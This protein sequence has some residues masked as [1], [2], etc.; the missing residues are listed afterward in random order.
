MSQFNVV[1]G[2]IFIALFSVFA[3][4]AEGEASGGLP[5]PQQP[6]HSPRIAPQPPV[7]YAPAPEPAP[8]W[9][10]CDGVD[11]VYINNY[12]ARIYPFLDDTPWLQPYRF[13]SIVTITNMGY[14]TVEA[15]AMGIDFQHNEILVDAEGI[16]LEDGRLMPVDV[17][18]GTVLTQ[19]P[20]GVLK[21]AIETAGDMNQVQKTFK[22]KGTEFGKKLD[23]MPRSINI[24]LKG[25]NC[26]ESLLYGNNTMHTCCSE[27]NRNVT[28]N[29]EEFFL[30]P[31][32][33][34]FTIMYDVIQAYPGSYLA[35]VTL[36][37]DSPIARLDFWNI[38]FTWQEN[39]FITKMMGA[40]TREADREVCMN[41]IAGKTYSD[42]DMNN[43]FC[44]SV[45]PEIV[46]L[47]IDRTNDTQIG[48]IEYCCRNGTLWPAL[49]DEKKS[50]SAFL[51]NVYKVPPMSSQLNHIIPP[52]NWRIGDGR[53][54]CGIPRRIKPTAYLDP[55]LLYET[56]AF[57][58]WQVT[59]N[60]TE[61]KPPPKCCVSFSKYTNDSIVP[62]RTCACGCP[63]SPQPACN[64]SASA[65]LL[66][67]SAITMHPENRTRQI[68]AWA[69]I[70]HNKN[71]PNPLPCQ[72]Y[73]GVAINWHIV[74]NFT[75][76]WSSRMTLF[77]WSDVTFPDWF[78]VLQMPGAYQGF[79]QAYSFNATK[80]P[81]MNGTAPDNTSVMVTGLQ[82]L[83][84]LMAATNRSAG[85][86][87]SVF[88]YTKLTTSGMREQDYFPEKVW[89]NGE[90][91]VMPEGFP[92]SRSGALPTRPGVLA[93]A[94]FLMSCT[95]AFYDFLG[96]L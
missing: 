27:P 41:G 17:S 58:T 51:M 80:M 83:N 46:D 26:S 25:Y 79:Q 21:N 6:L 30:N 65:M 76:G 77:D 81:N 16:V 4:S 20:A 95:M 38:S 15:W 28:L 8:L 22:I 23:P 53:F 50:K 19:I 86:L 11:I 60:E 72:D 7:L 92:L 70:N 59:C 37:N 88:S 96:I 91:C 68:L 94:I 43:V 57:K 74:S 44:C 9:P 31:E 84:Y 63:A 78:A 3:T 12:T 1:G 33:G 2:V 34:N 93:F 56:T 66:P 36:S 42:P 52:G 18:N 75:G 61:N 39:E 90:E 48:G 24:T 82:G 13:E 40:T 49:L 14:S 64:A 85:K 32:T 87:Q 45:S 89:F 67:Y 29:D 47:P 73:C 69:D 10:P 54:K 71:I 5:I 55:Y 62:C 35:H